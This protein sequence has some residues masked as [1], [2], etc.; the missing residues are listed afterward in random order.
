[1]CSSDLTDVRASIERRF[2][3][4]QKRYFSLYG[5]HPTDPKNF[6]LVVETKDNDLRAVVDIVLQKYKQWQSGE[7]A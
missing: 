5:V 1:M 2:A 6:D 4:E 3:S 7:T